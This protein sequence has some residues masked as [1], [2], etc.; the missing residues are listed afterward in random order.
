M[1]TSIEY[2]ERRILWYGISRMVVLGLPTLVIEDFNFI[3]KLNEKI[4]S[5]QYIIVL[6]LKSSGGLSVTWD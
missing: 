3:V 2:R 5:R 4:S 6:I 1:Y